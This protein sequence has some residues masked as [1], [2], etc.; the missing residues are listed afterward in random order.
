LNQQGELQKS[1]DTGADL[2]SLSGT[3]DEVND[4]L[5]GA[6][7]PSSSNS[8]SSNPLPHPHPH[9]SRIPPY[10][11]SLSRDKDQQAQSILV[12]QTQLNETQQSLQNHVGKIRDLEIMLVQQEGIKREVSNLRSLMEEARRDMIMLMDN[13]PS[14]HRSY[15]DEEDHV[16]ERSRGNDGRESPVAAMLE[17]EEEG[18]DDEDARSISSV[19]TIGPHRSRKTSNGYQ[20]PGSSA[21]EPIRVQNAILST[22]LE[23]LSASLDESLVLSQSLR[24]QH[25]SA[26]STILALQQ[27][28]E[29][30]ER[31]VDVKV[32]SDR[33]E[34][35]KRWTTWKTVCE[36]GWN[37]ERE[38][39]DREREKLLDLV[40]DWEDARAAEEEEDDLT[41]DEEEVVEMKE[42]TEAIAG[43]ADDDDAVTRVGS[44]SE[45]KTKKTKGATTR[46]RRRRFSSSSKSSFPLSG[47]STS[48]SQDE[49]Q[50]RRSRESN[51]RG[52]TR[53]QHP[54]G[55]G[56]SIIISSSNVS[57]TFLLHFHFQADNSDFGSKT[58][59]LP[60]AG[61]GIVVLV[62]IALWGLSSKVKD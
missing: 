48:S 19:D 56:A 5:S 6:T 10:I 32:A 47:T 14:E 15:D 60:Y 41:D 34:S 1:R 23:T 9:P 16:S 39:W 53:S 7:L 38:S 43:E 45:G 59:M 54:K 51:E 30:L 50:L 22:R 11:P 8:S 36:E 4:T 33:E 20:R 27:R 12:L 46:R 58:A 52:T 13:R 31:M 3:L 55:R 24:A 29:G 37:R 17:A 40:R 57:F 44:G 2:G 62:G 35:E 25:T 21:I 61:A 18:E 26:S 28:V 42:G 49:R